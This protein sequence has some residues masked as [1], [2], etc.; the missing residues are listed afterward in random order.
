MT[1]GIRIADRISKI[2]H[3]LAIDKSHR[4]KLS[5]GYTLKMDEWGNLMYVCWRDAGVESDHEVC[6]NEIS[7]ITLYD[8]VD[9]ISDE[10]MRE[11]ASVVYSWLLKEGK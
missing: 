8:E 6:A 9:R 3:Y 5:N 4:V 2:L 1:Q 7:Y 11:Y 10:K